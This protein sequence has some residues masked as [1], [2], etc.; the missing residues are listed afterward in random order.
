MHSTSVL[1]T[2]K[3]I[4]LCA[5]TSCLCIHIHTYM[6]MGVDSESSN[7]YP[8]HYLDILTHLFTHS[9]LSHQK[10]RGGRGN[11]ITKGRIV[12]GWGG[13]HL[14]MLSNT[15]DQWFSKYMS[16]TPKLTLTCPHF[17][18]YAREP[19]IKEDFYSSSSDSHSFQG[20]QFDMH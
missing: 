14:N 12:G 20:P 17:K 6:A 19:Q 13:G 8:S 4:Q 15:V 1:T 2:N 3:P 16:R 9:L 10:R 5:H 18:R 11:A 7:R